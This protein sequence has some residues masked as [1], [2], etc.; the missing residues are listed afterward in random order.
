MLND[1]KDKSWLSSLINYGKWYFIS[2]VL[3]KG[4]SVLLLPIY[5]RYLSPE[6]FGVLQSL[7][8]IAIFLPILLSCSLDSAIARYY[9]NLKHD[10]A[11]LAIMFSTIFWFVTVYG[12][13]F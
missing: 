8:S 9:H 1:K 2:S 5:T 12:L 13:L 7:N 3:T 10:N 6:D 11:K 4:L